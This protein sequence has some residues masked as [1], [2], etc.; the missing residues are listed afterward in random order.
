MNQRTV[1][2]A[3]AEIELQAAA[4]RCGVSLKVGGVPPNVRIDCPYNCPG[5]HAGKRELSVNVENAD[6][7][8]Q[9]HN[10]ECHFRGN[11]IHLMHGWLTG[12]KPPDGKVR[13]DDFKRVKSVLLSEAPASPATPSD[14]AVSTDRQAQDAAEPDLPKRN[15]PLSESSNEKAREL[16]GMESVLTTDPAKMTPQCSAYW[17][18]RRE[19][20]TD[21]LCDEWGVGVR[22][23]RAGADRRGWSLRN[24][25]VYRFLSEDNKVLCYVGRDPD[26][27]AKLR[28]FESLPSEQRDSTKRPMKHKFPVGFHRGLELYGQHGDRLKQH[29][30]YRDL[31]AQHGIIVVEGFNDVLAL[32]NHGVPAVAICSNR[33]TEQ[34]A[35]KVARWAKQFSDG[36]V[37]LMFDCEES[38]DEG[39]KEASWL[40]ANMFE[41]LRVELAWSLRKLNGQFRDQQPETLTI[42]ELH[43]LLLPAL[44]R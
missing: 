7:V 29:P 1:D 39:A 18:T 27:D 26:Y 4:E 32:D 43:N 42:D 5:D 16:V 15:I 8:F 37:S 40:L 35:A 24:H 3:K 31:V 12:Q 21:E 10:Y 17:R 14:T 11:L 2:Q 44:R 19:F 22:R 9:C 20:L 30:E 38:G 6:K 23:G 41:G 34:Q 13:G 36:K 33:M 25:V 28:T